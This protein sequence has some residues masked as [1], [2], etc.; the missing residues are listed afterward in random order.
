MCIQTNPG[1]VSVKMT[2][3][4]VIALGAALLSACAALPT[5][6]TDVSA[7]AD[8]C[9]VLLHGLVRTS[10]SLK[11]MEEYIA[12]SGY[13]VHNY[14]Y[15]SRKMPIEALASESIPAAAQT[16][17]DQGTTRISF[18]THSM[19]GILLRYY[20][21]HEELPELGRVVM[22]SPPNQGSELV[23]VWSEV[24]G[25]GALNGPAG[26][27][28]GTDS[29]S[30]P[31][32]LGRADFEVGVIAGTN[33]TNPIFS[34]MIP[35]EDDGKVSVDRTRLEGMAD[36]LVVPAAHSLI[37][38]DGAVMQQVVHFLEHGKFIHT[39]QAQ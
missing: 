23:D 25:Y 29:G 36:F 26:Y 18:V 21:E 11:V 7:R 38:R 31:L 39:A 20:L 16:C 8:E 5:I 10:A 13:T 1:L 6:T 33:T 32:Q 37:M 17:R 35:G 14:S 30:L 9:V 4:I 15:P 12:A 34:L 27:Q 3:C 24:P 28:L 2:R 19:G 22:I